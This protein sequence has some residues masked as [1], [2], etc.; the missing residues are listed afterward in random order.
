MQTQLGAAACSTSY[1]DVFVVVAS[2]LFLVL[3]FVVL[4]RRTQTTAQLLGMR[5]TGCE[6]AEDLQPFWL[7]LTGVAMEEEEYLSLPEYAASVTGTW[8]VGS[9]RSYL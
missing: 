1:P 7:L 2:L 9:I 4:S 6:A 5:L 8:S 3:G